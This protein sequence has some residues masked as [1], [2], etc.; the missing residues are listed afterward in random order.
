MHI[1]LIRKQ[2][3]YARNPIVFCLLFGLS[4]FFQLEPLAQLNP[5]EQE[6]E[7]LAL[8]TLTP[9]KRG[10]A[11]ARESKRRDH[12]WN[13]SRVEMVMLL[14][15]KQGDESI[16]KLRT[17]RLEVEGD[18]DKSLNI[19]DEP[20]DIAGT[21]FLSFSHSLTADEQW[22]Y[23]P[24]L[25]RVKR[26]S[27]NNKSGPFMGSEFSYEDIGSF[28]VEK[29]N[30]R[31]LRDEVYR[32]KPVFV[33]EMRPQYKHSG[34]TRQVVWIDKAEY[35]IWKIDFYDRKNS[36]LKTLSNQNYHLFLDQ[37][38][39]QQKMSMVNH[40]TGKSTVLEFHNFRFRVGLSDKDFNRNQLKRAR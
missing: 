17:L 40:Q 1:Y 10:L 36:L 7:E 12:G 8:E 22:M 24:A 23:F 21:A 11:I 28:E 20:R 37:Y 32:D 30:H 15:N 33:L 35:R 2:H 5:E 29:Y 16:R 26:I 38:W 14:R 31:W 34:Y 4:V 19:F 39:R 3:Q 18:G 25:K 9:E 6:P 27:S 13:D